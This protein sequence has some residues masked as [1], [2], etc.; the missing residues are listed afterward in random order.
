MKNLRMVGTIGSLWLL[1]LAVAVIFA[2]G[3]QMLAIR[4]ADSYEDAGVHSF[5]AYRVLP[6]Q[7][8]NTGAA[9]RY[10]RMNPTRTV[11]K[12]HYLATD[13]SGYQ[14][15]EQVMSREFGQDMVD[16]EAETERRVLRIPA[17]GTYI[18]VGAD[19][20]AESYTAGLRQKYV[21]AL[22][23]SGAYIL[24]Y[25]LV[26]IVLWVRRNGKAA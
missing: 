3:R 20:T 12:V 16:A 9:G 18:T 4:P 11:Y 24:L 1:L 13:G 6:S 25:L 10:R 17:D 19:Q 2:A 15:S 26:K 5:L 23:P 7:M 22:V 14:W 21:Q 8:L